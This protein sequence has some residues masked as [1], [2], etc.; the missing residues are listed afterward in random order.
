MNYIEYKNF[1]PSE[2]QRDFLLR[3]ERGFLTRC[4][5]AMLKKITV[6]KIYD[7][8]YVASVEAVSLYHELSSVR[9]YKNY[10]DAV[11]YSF[12]SAEMCYLDSK[13]TFDRQFSEYETQSIYASDIYLKQSVAPKNLLMVGG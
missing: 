13:N 6:M 4:P 8:T 2:Q 12:L 3:K 11:S 1:E 9:Y 10:E 7:S 5:D